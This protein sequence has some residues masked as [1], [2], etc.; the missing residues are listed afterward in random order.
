MVE[1]KTIKGTHDLLP[2]ELFIW[3]R[4]ENSIHNSMQQY[5]YYEIRTPVFENTD[6]FVRGIGSETDIVTKDRILDQ[7]FISSLTYKVQN[8]YSDTV[9]LENRSIDNLINKTYQ[10]LTIR[11][12]ENIITK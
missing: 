10:E 9:N 3:R 5:G 12:A 8:K 6:L 4:L 11:L 7:V 1:Y 2:D